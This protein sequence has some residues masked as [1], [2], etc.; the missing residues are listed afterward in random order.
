M[1]LPFPPE[2]PSI[3]ENFGPE[4]CGPEHEI[5]FT[6]ILVPLFSVLRGPRDAKILELGSYVGRSTKMFLDLDPSV[7]LWCV[8]PWTDPEHFYARELERYG[9]TTKLQDQF[10]RNLWPYRDR[11]T[12]F[13]GTSVQGMEYHYYGGLTFDAIYIDGDHSSFWVETDLSYAFRL[14]P[15]AIIFG[16]D[17]LHFAGVRIGV[18]R[19]CGIH[20]LGF[21]TH[22]PVWTLEK[23]PTLNEWK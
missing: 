22:G 15:D 12:V 3:P 10:F 19:F 17:W 21:K 7:K 14:W 11:I 9:S 13:Q 6:E 8:D 1:I 18:S 5:A 23:D 2:C 4:W 16:D 20:N